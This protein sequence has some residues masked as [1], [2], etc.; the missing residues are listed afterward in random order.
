LPP[1][2]LP[3]LI[4]LVFS[5]VLL[6]LTQVCLSNDHAFRSATRK[7]S[8]RMKTGKWLVIGA[9]M[10][11]FTLGTLDSTIV[12]TAMPRIVGKLGG[13]NLYSWVFSIYL[14]AST[15][16]VPIYGKLADLYGRKP[17]LFTGMS[18]FLAGSLAC[19]LAQSM[20]Q[21]IVFRALQGMGAG[22]IIPVVLAIIADI[23]ETREERNR[24]QGVIGMIWGI[25]SL[26]GPVIGGLIVDN[27]D[28]P[29]VFLLNLPIGLF[30]M[31]LLFIYFK[32]NR[33]RQKHQL[34]YLGTALLTGAV[35]ALLLAL[36]QGGTAWAWASFQSI[37]LLVGAVVLFSI[38][39]RVEQR[40]PE[41]V[42]PLS[43]FKNRT[44]AIASIGGFCLGNLMYGIT[45][46]VP[47]FVQGVK[48]S[49]AT[50]AGLV[51]IPQSVTW[52]LVSMVIAR[53]LNRLGY[54]RTVRTGTVLAV[55]GVGMLT[56]FGPQ[57]PL[58][59]MLL[60]MVII[61]CG[62]GLQSNVYTLSVQQ[63]APKNLIG[64]ASAS[65]QFVRMIGGTLGVA[66][67]GAILNGQI[68]QR[69]APLMAQHSDIVRRLPKDVTPAN[70]LLAPE[71][72]ATLPPDFLSQL[73]EAL[74]QSLFWVY[75][76]MLGLT[77][78]VF[79][80]MRFYPRQDTGQSVPVTAEAKMG[81]IG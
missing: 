4:N 63:S 20:E 47:L 68:S 26:L 60:V 33:A 52:S 36:L 23:S 14:L 62:F 66:V 32:E 24:L 27:L 28:W 50:E 39:L 55:L 80:T 15:T 77:L 43:L 1:T 44:I 7:K 78:V 72:R 57:T 61:G 19:G 56:L 34:D 76:L 17:I 41:P 67:M 10:T 81:E 46:Y 11:G 65:T 31:L 3:Q 22:G 30:A 37:G 45:S 40:A 2:I 59:F 42:I 29:W 49:P 74:S 69:F 70:I 5:R 38:F 54:Q 51:L 48:G 12:A 9:L 13:I 6:Y 21:L 71:L 18:F 75:L 8:Q 16:T 58:P 79:G 64:V 53:I 73:E 35:I 25:S